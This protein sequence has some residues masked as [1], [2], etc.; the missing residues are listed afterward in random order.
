MQL[1]HWIVYGI[2]STEENN[3]KCNA[4]HPK[5]PRSLK[6]KKSRCAY[7]SL[8]GGGVLTSSNEYDSGW[9]HINKSKLWNNKVSK[10][11]VPEK[12]SSFFVEGSED[13]AI[14]TAADTLHSG[15]IN[16]WRRPNAFFW[17]SNSEEV[18]PF[19]HGDEVS[20]CSTISMTSNMQVTGPINTLTVAMAVA[21]VPMLVD[22]VQLPWL[23]R[24]LMMK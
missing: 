14:R 4:R 16:G 18:M 10:D 24:I 17:G 9:R 3:L 12:L 5:T 21:H 8:Q 1:N 20:K 22:I 11:F 6:K 7:N 2:D 23:E 19:L 13:I 15:D